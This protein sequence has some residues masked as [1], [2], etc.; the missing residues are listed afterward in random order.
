[1]KPIAEGVATEEQLSLGVSEM[2]PAKAPNSL[3][4]GDFGI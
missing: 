4:D 2:S 1:M 3:I